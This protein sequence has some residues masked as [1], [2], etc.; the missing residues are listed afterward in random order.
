VNEP[1]FW[2]SAFLDF[3]PDEYARGVGFWSTVTGYA[4]SPTR[5]DGGEFATLVPPDGD[6]YL[7]VQRLGAGS[8]RIHLDLHVEDPAAAADEAAARG[9]DVVDRND[10]GYVVMRSPGGLAFCLVRHPAGS[11]PAPAS[12]LGVT[13]S[14]IYQVCLDLP[15]ASYDAECAFWAGLVTGWW[16]C[17]R[18]GR[19]SPGCGWIASSP[20]T[21]CSSAATPARAT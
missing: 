5:G 7:R 2:L 21:C 15:E 3:A 6:D 1:P 10:L 11:V 12:W 14:R 17:C 16:R 18:A 8:G 4:A 9:A 20:S 19:S 13:R